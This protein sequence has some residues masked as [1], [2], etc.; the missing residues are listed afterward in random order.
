MSI[1]AKNNEEALTLFMEKISARGAELEADAAVRFDQF[2]G[3]LKNGKL[4]NVCDG[5]GPL[6]HSA[7]D[8][9]QGTIAAAAEQ[10]LADALD[11]I[12]GDRKRNWDRGTV[13]VRP[14]SLN[15]LTSPRS[16]PA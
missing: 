10:A 16:Q 1:Y 9:D 8:P 15:R 7:T 4:P 14:G 3:L 13:P 2:R 6:T 11:E 12:E 5:P